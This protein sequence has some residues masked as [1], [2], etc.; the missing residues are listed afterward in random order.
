M[1]IQHNLSKFIKKL[2]RLAKNLNA[3]KN[4]VK[5]LAVSKTKP[6]SAILSSYQAGQTAF[7]E[8]CVQEGVEKIQPGVSKVL[9]LNGILSGP[10]QSNKTR[11]VAEH[12][13]WMETLDRAKITRSFK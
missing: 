10:L 12:F 13:D 2:K 3:I 8:K 7:R 5:L 4:T 9:T 6:I 1:D 11:P